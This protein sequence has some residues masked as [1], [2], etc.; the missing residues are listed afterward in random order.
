MVAQSSK[1]VEYQAM[2]VAAYELMWIKQIL[3]ELKFGDID[4]NRTSV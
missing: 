2:A 1:E 4:K 3:K